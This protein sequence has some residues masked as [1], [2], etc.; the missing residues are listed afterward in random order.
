[1]AHV[2]A[3]CSF[4]DAVSFF[5]LILRNQLFAM[6]LC[7]Q[8]QPSPGNN[9]PHAF[10]WLKRAIQRCIVK[11]MVKYEKVPCGRQRA[12]WNLNTKE[13]APKISLTN[14]EF[15]SDC[16]TFKQQK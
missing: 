12:K 7:W 9:P 4:I 10:S 13:A 15:F 11:N 1:M 16:R 3:S 14:T 5:S 8:S 2:A 6:E